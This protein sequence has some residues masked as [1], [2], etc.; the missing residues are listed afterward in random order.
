M[1]T[2]EVRRSESSFVA[3]FWTIKEIEA[4]VIVMELRTLVGQLFC[5]CDFAQGGISAE[6]EEGKVWVI[7]EVFCRKAAGQDVYHA[8]SYNCTIQDVLLMVASK[9]HLF[10]KHKVKSAQILKQPDVLRPLH[11]FVFLWAEKQPRS[12]WMNWVKDRTPCRCG[13]AFG[14][15]WRAQIPRQSQHQIQGMV[16]QLNGP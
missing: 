13:F 2:K 15:F 3:H 11:M 12:E 10:Y 6:W 7:E 5:E 14:I 4:H 16:A 9:R 8:N 1:V